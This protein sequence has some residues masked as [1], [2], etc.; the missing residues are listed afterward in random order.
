M[1][2]L[3]ALT[4][5]CSDVPLSETETSELQNRPSVTNDGVLW[6]VTLEL[7][8]NQC[9]SNAILMAGSCRQDREACYYYNQFYISKKLKYIIYRY[10]LW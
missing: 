5:G 10:R 8:A 3:K 6:A 1:H 2:V 7:E 9:F 4:V